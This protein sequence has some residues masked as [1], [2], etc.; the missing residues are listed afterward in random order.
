M[1]LTTHL[2]V[3]GLI[4][5]GDQVLLVSQKAAR[6]PA[7]SYALP[8]GRVEPGELLTNALIREV[9]EE[10]G[11]EV[12]AFG[13]LLYSLQAVNAHDGS[14]TLVYV[15][16]ISEWRGA[17]QSADPDGFIMSAH[18]YPRVEAIELLERSLPWRQM[19]EPI[20]AHLRREVGVG[21]V[22]L[23]RVGLNEASELIGR[24]G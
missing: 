8:G 14:Q 24:L 16:N 19:R 6:D 9:R 10:T 1:T 13:P 5:D 15:F 23:Y 21:A 3:A 17:L 7:P 2:V 4:R 20:V 22:W 18:F 11:L 12:T